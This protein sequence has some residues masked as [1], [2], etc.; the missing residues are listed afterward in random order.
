MLLQ[1]GFRVTSTDASDKMLMYAMKERWNRRKQPAFDNWGM[2]F[3]MPNQ[4]IITST[5]F[6]GTFTAKSIT[7]TKGGSRS[8]RWGASPPSPP[9]PSYPSPSLAPP[10]PSLFFPFP[11]IP[12]LSRPSPPLP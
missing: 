4:S 2:Y 8:C 3:V 1:E 11:S 12:P 5:E 10:F 6:N 9:L 7:P